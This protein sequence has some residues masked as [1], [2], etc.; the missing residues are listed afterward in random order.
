[1]RAL[2]VVERKVRIQPRSRG[3]DI[4]VRGQKNI[5]ILHRAPQAFRK[6]VVHAPSPA[7]HTDLHIFSGEEI[8]VLRRGEMAALIGIV[9][10]RNAH[11]KR[12]L[13]IFK[14]EINIQRFGELP[15]DHIA[16]VPIEQ[17]DQIAKPL[18]QP[19]VGDVRAPDLIWPQDGYLAQ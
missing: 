18:L 7:I 14:T 3:V 8:R 5:F 12:P 19:Y 11:G 13:Q 9:H 15:A 6:D 17:G 2:R 4:R 16:R 10:F 1:M